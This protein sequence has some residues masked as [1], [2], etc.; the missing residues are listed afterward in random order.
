MYIHIQ[1]SCMRH[2]GVGTHENGILLNN[3]DRENY[4]QFSGFRV[5]TIFQNK[6]QDDLL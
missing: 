2:V 1:L 5:D 6:R 3:A 4:R